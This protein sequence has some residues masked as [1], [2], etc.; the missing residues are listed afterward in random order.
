MA[1]ARIRKLEERDIDRAIELTDLEGWGYTRADFQRL[2]SLHPEGCLAAVDGGRLVGLLS[3]TAYG[4]VAFLGAVIV[5]PDRRGHGVGGAMM[6]AALDLLDDRGVETVRLNAYLHVVP[7]YERLGFRR[8]YEN[9]RWSR[10]PMPQAG[11]GASPADPAELERIVSFD[12]PFFGAR[13]EALL[14]YLWREFPRTSLAAVRDGRIA[15]YLVG[16]TSAASCEIG[17]WI[18]EPSADVA[19]HLLDGLVRASAAEAYAFTAPA[20]NRA[21]R[22]FAETRGFEE[23]FRTLRMVRGAAGSGGRPE[24]VWGLAGLEKG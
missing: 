24:G 9:V 3:T 12:E 23:V 13:R 22:R 20:P 1:G 7:F 10:G 21:A 17:P 6:R 11:T 14:A 4:P 15:G 8:E 2:M 16:N 5:D 18:V 19:P